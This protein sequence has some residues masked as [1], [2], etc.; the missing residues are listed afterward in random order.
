MNV[1]IFKSDLKKV[2]ANNPQAIEFDF[3]YKGLERFKTK[4]EF[5]NRLIELFGDKNVVSITLNIV[6]TKND[7]AGRGARLLNC[8]KEQTKGIQTMSFI[9]KTKKDLDSEFNYSQKS[10]GMQNWMDAYG[11]M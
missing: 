7:F 8:I 6:K 9:V 4:K 5:G 11:T 10:S 1:Q 2:L 3:F